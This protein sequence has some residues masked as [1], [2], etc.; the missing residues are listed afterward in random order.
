MPTPLFQKGAKPTPPQAT[1]TCCCTSPARCIYSGGGMQT[2]T[3]HVPMKLFAIFVF[4]G[5]RRVLAER[6]WPTSETVTVVVQHGPGGSHLYR[7]GRGRKPRYN[8]HS[9]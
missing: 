9:I 7:R 1:V 5:K 8:T 2:L 4:V 6:L 3:P